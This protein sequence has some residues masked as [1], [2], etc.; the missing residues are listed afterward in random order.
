MSNNINNQDT[1][2]SNIG[3]I[4]TFGS[5]HLFFKLRLEK[6]DM[7]FENFLTLKDLK[8][9]TF[10]IENEKLWNRI[11]LTTNNELLNVLLQANKIKIYKNIISYLV[12]SKIEYNEEQQKFQKL[13]DSVL[14]DNGLVILSYDICKCKVS[15]NL[16]ISFN[17]Y[18][19]KYCLY[20]EEDYQEYDEEKSKKSN[21][22]NNNDE[23]NKNNEIEN[24][25]SENNK[26]KN[27]ENKNDENENQEDNE[28]EEE[29]EEDINDLG[30]FE[31]IPF[32]EIKFED[33]K[34]I[35]IH[36]KDYINDGEFSSQFKLHQIYN[37]LKKLKKRCKI[38][39]FINFGED[40]GKNQKY[41]IKLLRISDIHL[42]RDKNILFEMMKKKY[43]DEGKKREIEKEK[44]K[45]LFKTQ[46]ILKTLKTHKLNK[47]SSMTTI[48]NN[49]TFNQSSI[50][51][52]GNNSQATFNNKTLNKS[53]SVKDMLN[54]ICVTG[55]RLNKNFLGKNNIYKYLKEVIYMIN[56]KEKHP[57]YNDKLGI[58]LDE[59]KKIYIV[60]YKKDT[61]IPNLTQ[62]D[63]NIYPKTNIYSA[64]EINKIRNN[65]LMKYHNKY[66][67]VLY[68]SILSALMDNINCDSY[69]HFIL[70]YYSRISI[71]KILAIEK[72]KLPIPKDKSFYFVQID[73]N[74]LKKIMEKDN[75]K[76][77]EE[78]FNNNHFQMKYGGNSYKY[79]PL[80]DKFLTSYLQSSVNI[81]ILKNRNLINEKKKIL[82]DPEYKELY[83]FINPPID[84]N[85]NKL[86]TFIMKANLSKNLNI[87]E[88]DYK[89]EFLSKKPEMK[90]HLPGING[91]P[92][93][94]MYL[95]KSERKKMKQK[96]L[97]PLKKRKEK[98]DEENKDEEKNK[99]KKKEEKEIEDILLINMRLPKDEEKKEMLKRGANDENKEKTE[100]NKDEEKINTDKYKEIKFQSTPL[101]ANSIEK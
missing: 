59:Y 4:I 62:Y 16:K 70:Y 98:N 79:Y 3:K 95:N 75:T 21:D 87:K 53:Q 22:D 13:I 1:K 91:I 101:E 80:M 35:Y 56:L 2:K 85:E 89:K 74:E 82:Y 66:T 30:P 45:I 77:K 68:G 33:F 47:N 6:E 94:Y 73:K 38:K 100:E 49:K 78:G 24:K 11:E 9:L 54:S 57:N 50:S 51:K 83:K 29:K 28:N 5:L 92:E 76:R 86:A 93:Y 40:F 31:K 17:K 37:F 41:I 7:T 60:D 14:L 25:N 63:L 26:N 20:G 23:G 44:M 46:K 71:L 39:I 15:I 96:K 99:A 81:D 67:N 69:N 65:Y 32:D 58:Y 61:F 10:L 18:I 72:N 27:E 55:G 12:Y 43:E 88:K 90:Y 42:F 19:H 48:R 34:C 36:F 8:N 52:E 97:P 84:L 64:N